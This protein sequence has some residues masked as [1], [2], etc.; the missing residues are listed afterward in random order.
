[1]LFQTPKYIAPF[2]IMLVLIS[3]FLEHLIFL[4]DTYMLNVMRKTKCKLLFQSNNQITIWNILNKTS[5]GQ[6]V[7]NQPSGNPVKMQINFGAK[8]LKIL[9]LLLL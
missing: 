3:D 9:A 8:K 2:F 1:M 5:L 6:N 4:F 7:P